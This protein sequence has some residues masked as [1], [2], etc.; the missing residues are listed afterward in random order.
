MDAIYES[1]IGALEAQHNT[2]VDAIYDAIS[3]KAEELTGTFTRDIDAAAK[4]AALKLD[5]KIDELAFETSSKVSAAKS[6]LNKKI[7]D[8]E[9]NAGSAA[10]H[11]AEIDS[12]VKSTNNTV[13]SAIDRLNTAELDISKLTDELTRLKELGFGDIVTSE[14]IG[15]LRAVEARVEQLNTSDITVINKLYSVQSTVNSVSRQLKELNDKHKTDVDSLN[16]NFTSLRD[17]LRTTESDLLTKLNTEFTKLW[18]EITDLVD[19]D[20]VLY[21]HILMVVKA[22][23]DIINILL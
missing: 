8:L 3:E 11:L 12:T 19:D 2:D 21:N 23:R 7:L 15:Q 18:A 10:S 14:V 1:K 5:T 9:T 16:T 4:D 17:E 13:T 6:E 20:I 22:I